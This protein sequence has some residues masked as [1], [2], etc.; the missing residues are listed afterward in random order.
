[1]NEMSLV[2]ICI[3][4]SLINNELN[5]IGF[6]KQGDADIVRKI[7]SVLP[8]SKYAGIITTLHNMALFIDKLMAFEMSRKMGSNEAAS[9]S[10]SMALSHVSTRRLRAR[11]K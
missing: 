4:L 7:I 9:S 3:H 2:E 10:K 6:I 1:M 5:S 8:H 11:S